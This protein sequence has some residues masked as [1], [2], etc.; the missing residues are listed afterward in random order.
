MQGETEIL[1]LQW[2]KLGLVLTVLSAI[3][4]LFAIKSLKTPRRHGSYVP[5][6]AAVVAQKSP[7]SVELVGG[8][9]YAW[10]ACGLSAKQPFCDGAHKATDMK[11]LIFTAPISG[12]SDLCGCK[13]S[14]NAPYC[15][16]AHN[17]I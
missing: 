6:K 3:G 16:G 12:L 10:C 7:C 17:D 9:K 15:N 2:G 11:P 13:M 14:A 8:E 4:I 5:F 1:G